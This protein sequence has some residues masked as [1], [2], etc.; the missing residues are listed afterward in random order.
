MTNTCCRLT[1]KQNARLEVIQKYVSKLLGENKSPA[2]IAKEEGVSEEEVRK[3]LSEI[4]S[5]TGNKIAMNEINNAIAK[6][7]A[8]K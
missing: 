2:Q 3:G 5:I 7:D 8:E 1:P 4:L 6:F